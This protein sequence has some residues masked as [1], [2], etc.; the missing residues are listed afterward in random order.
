MKT[1]LLQAFL[2]FDVFLAGAIAATALRHAYAHFRPHAHGDDRLSLG[3]HLPRAVREK[4]LTEAQ[5]NF[6]SVLRA[7]T[8]D[9]QKDLADTAVDIKKQIEETGNEARDKEIAHYKAT[10]AELQNKSQEDVADM[11]KDLA[12]QKAELR[13]KLA[14]EMAAEKKKLLDAID[15][16]LA[17]AVASFLAETL[18]RDVDLGSQTAYLTRMLEEHKADF[19]REVSGES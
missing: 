7:A 12:A 15:T 6:E 9:L 8:R 1:T 16:K 10:L 11:D 3:G 14:E 5:T 17:D 4:L 18:G 13:A 2:I 19:A